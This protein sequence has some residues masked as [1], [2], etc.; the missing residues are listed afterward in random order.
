MNGTS[1]Y[2]NSENGIEVE[3]GSSDLISGNTVSNV[4]GG[5]SCSV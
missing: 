4:G 5:I 1:G 2:A 3:G